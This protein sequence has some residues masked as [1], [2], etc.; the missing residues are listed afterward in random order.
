[1]RRRVKTYYSE[2][3]KMKFYFYIGWTWDDYSR[4]VSKL[5]GIEKLGESGR[6]GE[7]GYNHAGVVTIWTNRGSG[8]GPIVH[9]CFH[10]VGFTFGAIGVEPCFR[11]DEAAAYFLQHLVE[12][13]MNAAK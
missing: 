5:F 2:L 6:D 7:C 12:K 1:M 3:Y 13:A 9:E 11:N 8:I 4:S 10:A